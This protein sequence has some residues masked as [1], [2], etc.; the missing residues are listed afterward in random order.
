MLPPIRLFQFYA[1]T[2]VSQCRDR[3]HA[4]GQILVIMEL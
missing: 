3:L 4:V 1:D 2:F